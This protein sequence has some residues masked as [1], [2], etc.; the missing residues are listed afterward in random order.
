METN[1]SLAVIAPGI[2]EALY[3]T[4]FGIVCAIPGVLFYNFYNRAFSS[5]ILIL[6]VFLQKTIMYSL[7]K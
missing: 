4:A 3:L 5:N 6:E 2:S 1:L 7:N